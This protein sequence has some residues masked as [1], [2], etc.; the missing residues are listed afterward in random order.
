VQR[1]YI[2]KTGGLRIDAKYGPIEQ[3]ITEYDY[4]KHVLDP[5]W[6]GNFLSE[7][8]L[9]EFYTFIRE[10]YVQRNQKVIIAWRDYT[11]IVLAG[12]TG[13]RGREIVKLDALGPH[14]DIFYSPQLRNT[15]VGGRV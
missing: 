1:P 5:E 14:R 6:E 7:E 15:F 11:M 13:L 10:H 4:P 3:P 9:H 2:P 8:Q 12:E